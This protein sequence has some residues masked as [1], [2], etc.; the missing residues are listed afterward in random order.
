VRKKGERE[1]FCPALLHFK[2]SCMRHFGYRGGKRKEQETGKGG[3]KGNFH[4]PR[5]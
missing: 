3:R 4:T 1:E 2:P 5:P